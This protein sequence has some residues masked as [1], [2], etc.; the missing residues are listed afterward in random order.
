MIESMLQYVRNILERPAAIGAASA[1]SGISWL[2]NM[3][4]LMG[5]YVAGITA[6]C[7]MGGLLV[8]I[9]FNALREIREWKEHKRSMEE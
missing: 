9:V 3:I 2:A 4:K 5:E 8:T 7:A 6:L 1:V